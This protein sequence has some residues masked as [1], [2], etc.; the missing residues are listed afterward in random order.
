MGESKREVRISTI[1][2]E[3]TE[4]DRALFHKVTSTTLSPEMA[5]EFAAPDT[6]Y[7]SKKRILAIHWHPEH[8][9]L[10]LVRRRL[11]VM[12]PNKV[13]ELVI[14]TQHN[15]IMEM[16]GYAGLEI[17]CFS[18]EFNRKVQLL[19]HF[20]TGRLEDADVLKD[21]VRHTFKYRSKQLREIIDTCL[22][23]SLNERFGEAVAHTG[24]SE[25][26]VEFVGIYVGKVSGMLDQE[27]AEIAP[28]MIKNKLI[29]H[30][31][32][33]LRPRYG[34][35]TINAAQHLVRS[36]KQIVKREF[37]HDYFYRTEEVIEEARSRN[38][39][40]V[41]PHPEQ[42]WPILLAGYDVDGYEVWNPQSRQY[43]EF[44]IHTVNRENRERRAGRRP[45]LFFMG[46]DTHLGEKVRPE[47]LRD[48]EKAGREVGYQPAWSEIEIRKGLIL[49][50]FTKEKI[51]DEYKERLG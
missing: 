7:P 25:E 51:I 16:D 30:Y 47:E 42:F 26:V 36:V 8:I 37:Q 1:D 33:E 44:L 22:E 27:G 24:V 2:R 6:V 48:P 29:R 13:K 46:D 31:F 17:D 38:A 28:Q 19:L 32:D 39:G 45:L 50:G 34:D 23:P 3:I 49:G 9:P 12:F 20:S 11:D 18:P 5:R 43:T 40:I 35:R 4:E 10:D 14:P 21:M 41:V 15:S